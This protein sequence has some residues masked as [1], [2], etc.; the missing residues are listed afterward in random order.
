MLEPIR[1][2]R[3]TE[4]TF[5]EAQIRDQNPSLNRIWPSEPHQRNPNAPKLEDRSEEET[6]W[7]EHWARE[8]ACKLVENILKLKEKKK[9]NFFSAAEKW[10]L[11]SPSWTKVTRDRSD[12]I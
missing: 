2:V 11:P 3:F 12:L 4:A 1:S 6:E 10:C 8:V 7:K 5:F 9:T